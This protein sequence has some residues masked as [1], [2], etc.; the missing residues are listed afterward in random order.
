MSRGV[1]VSRAG[2]DDV[3]ALAALAA[4]CFSHPWT[5]AQIRD[6][7]ALGPPNGV[8]LAR[9]AATGGRPALPAAFCA[10]RLVLDELHVLDVAVH[11]A[12]RRRGLARFLLGL[13]LR[14]AA[15]AG[16]RVAL[17]EVRAGNAAALA[18]YAALGFRPVARRPAY[19]RDPVEDALLLERDGLQARC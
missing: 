7:I 6:E 11:P 5:A 8:L 18:L 17:L 19:Y 4:D 15:A 1:F 13:A 14:R 16:A 10:F 9:A 2:P 3:A 12:W